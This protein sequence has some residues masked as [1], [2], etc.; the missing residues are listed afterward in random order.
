MTTPTSVSGRP[1]PTGRGSVVAV[2]SVLALLFA[3]GCVA[4]G[5]P[6]SAGHRTTGSGDGRDPT[7]TTPSTT[8]A[9]PQE[10]TVQVRLS[11]GGQ[12]AIGTLADNP[13]ARDL[14]SLLPLTVPMSDLFGREKPGPLPRALTGDVEPVFTYR[15]GQI[16]YWPPGRDIFVVYDGDGLQVPSP[17]LVPLGTVDSGLDVVANA[18]DDFDMTIAVLD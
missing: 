7:E 12:E 10:G 18:G 3:S 4:G 11:I 17:G 14:V 1:R 9:P 16:A 2:A 5:D 15:I 8:A 13:A 6:S